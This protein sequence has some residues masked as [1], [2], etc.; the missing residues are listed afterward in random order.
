M[1]DARRARGER[2]ATLAARI[3]QTAPAGGPP[4]RSPSSAANAA[5]GPAGHEQQASSLHPSMWR[6][7]RTATPSLTPAGSSSHARRGPADAQAVLLMA[8][9]L[10]RYSPVD[11]FYEDWPDRIAE[12]VSAAGGSP[13]LPLSLPRPPPVM[14]D[15]AHGAP[16]PP[17]IQDVTLGP[18]RATPR[19]DPPRRAPARVEEICQEVRRPQEDA[20]V[21]PAPPCQDRAPP[22]VVARERQDQAPPPRRAPVTTAGCRAFT[23]ELR[24]V[25]WPRK[26]KPNPPPRYDGIPDPAES[27]GPSVT[28]A[29]VIAPSAAI[30][31]TTAVE[32]EMEDARMTAALQEW[33]NKPREER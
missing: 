22:A 18:R 8:R 1:A 24:S 9:E 12:L 32:A 11:D 21:L 2:R 17:P 28:G 19:R 23:P 26:F 25:V 30:E 13:A 15:V 10:L 6:D 7:G 31:A 3:A 16:P 4:R 14:G 27:L 20:P 5:I 29:S 33:R